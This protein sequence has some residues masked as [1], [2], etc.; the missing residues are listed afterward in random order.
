MFNPYL[1]KIFSTFNCLQDTF[2]ILEG[3]FSNL[4]VVEYGIFNFILICLEHCVNSEDPGPHYL[5]LI[6]VCIICPIKK[7]YAHI[8]LNHVAVK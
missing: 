8:S 7:R 5:E 1:L 3:S 2:P 6:L 4:S